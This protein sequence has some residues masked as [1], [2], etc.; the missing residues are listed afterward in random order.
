ML[1]SEDFLG[2]VSMIPMQG[3]APSP[4]QAPSRSDGG[5]LFSLTSYLTTSYGNDNATAIPEATE[6]D[7]ECTMSAID[8]IAA[9]RLDELYLQIA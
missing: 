4:I 6:R 2:G 7:I 1:Q 9:C 5:L 3:N 8:T